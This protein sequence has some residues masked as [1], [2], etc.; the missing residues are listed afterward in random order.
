LFSVLLTLPLAM[1][2][3]SYASRSV[4]LA[5]GPIGS[6]DQAGVMQPTI[7]HGGGLYKMWYVGT[8]GLTSGIGYAI[9][10]DGRQWNRVVDR[11]LTI[12]GW[13]G[14]AK[15]PSVLVRLPGWY[16]MWL[17]GDLI[18]GEIGRANSTEGISWTDSY[19]VLRAGPPGSWDAGG[20]GEPTVVADLS[21]YW[22][23]YVGVDGSGSNSSIGLAT[24][25]NG[26]TWTKSSSNPVLRPMAGSWTEKGLSSPG[27]AIR[28]GGTFQLCF[29]GSDSSA[30]RIGCALSSDGVTWNRPELVLDLGAPATAD[31][32]E[33]GGP[34]PSSEV[35]D[36]LWYSGFDGVTWRIL[37]AVPAQPPP[38]ASLMTTGTAAIAFTT[39]IAAV[40]A[41]AFV[42][43]DRFKY[44]FFAIPLAFRGVKEKNLDPFVRGQIYQYIRENPGDYYSSIMYAT[45][46]T[47]GNLAYHLHVLEKE[48]FITSSKEGRLVRFSPKGTP[49]PNGDGIRYSPLQ[50]R[51]LEQISRQPGIT[52]A[53]LGKALGVKKQTLAYNVWMLADSGVIEIRRIGRETDLYP[54]REEV[55]ER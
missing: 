26:L 52:Q 14:A 11:S 5:Q 2:A 12:S 18:G 22:M 38:I 42:T 24:S 48:G 16:Q 6:W 30:R 32:A 45:G 36:L 20:V 1:A 21:G 23:W 4:V 55:D 47:N 44:A 37:M 35:A 25:S 17:S 15:H 51:M 40:G 3:P 53:A 46:A 50:V 31:G 7:V 8:D 28:D 29:A 41:T 49:V 33:L 34:A 9:S 10:S 19:V 39:G 54:A 43:S 13:T 27:A